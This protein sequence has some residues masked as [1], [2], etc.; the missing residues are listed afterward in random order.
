VDNIESLSGGRPYLIQGEPIQPPENCLDV[1]LS[2]K[3]L[4][5]LLCVAFSHVSRCTNRD[6]LTKSSLLD[7]L[8]SK[9]KGREQFN[10]NLHQNVRQCWRRRDPGINIKSAEKVVEGPK[11][12]DKSVVAITSV[13]DRLWDSDVTGICKWYRRRTNSK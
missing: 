8:D 3:F 10:Y 6:E 1:L 4:H 2:P 9:G 7:L 11:Q 12:I 5:K 13:F